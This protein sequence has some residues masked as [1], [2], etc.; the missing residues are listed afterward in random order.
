MGLDIQNIKR[1]TGH[2][3]LLT[4][5]YVSTVSFVEAMVKLYSMIGHGRNFEQPGFFQLFIFFFFLFFPF[6]LLSLMTHELLLLLCQ[7]ESVI[8]GQDRVVDATSSGHFFV[9]PVFSHSFVPFK[10]Y[11]KKT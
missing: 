6:E 10:D 2:K 5:Y 7:D 11:E 4:M 9:L 1:L 8:Y 3:E